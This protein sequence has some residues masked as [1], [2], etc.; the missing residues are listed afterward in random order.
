MTLK[1]LDKNTW[2]VKHKD[3]VFYVQKNGSFYQIKESLDSKLWQE[4]Y[5]TLKYA[6]HEIVYLIDFNLI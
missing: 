2:S 6:Q 5:S 4:Q 3:R 1:E